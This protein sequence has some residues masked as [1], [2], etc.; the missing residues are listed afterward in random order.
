VH[1][2]DPEWSLWSSITPAFGSVRRH[3]PRSAGG[4]RPLN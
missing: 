2:P 3:R 4:G 1:F